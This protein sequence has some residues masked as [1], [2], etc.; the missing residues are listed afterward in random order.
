MR[1]GSSPAPPR[2][3]I[4]P[5][6]AAFTLS[7]IGVVMRHAEGGDA[8]AATPVHDSHATTGALTALGLGAPAGAGIPDHE[9]ILYQ[10]ELE[11]GR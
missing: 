1:G 3:R 2:P 8:I 11:A 9:A 4:D 6:S 10:G 5:A 7:Q